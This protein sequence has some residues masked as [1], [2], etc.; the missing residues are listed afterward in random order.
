LDTVSSTKL[1]NRPRTVTT[2]VPR[3]V[4]DTV[5]E[6]VIDNVARTVNTKV[7]RQVTTYDKVTVKH[8]RHG[9]GHGHGYGYGHG[10][11]YGRAY[12]NKSYGGYRKW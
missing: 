5:N 8:G 10:R 4:F 1:V 12:G 6:T 3:T 9:H 11:G 2:K 7:P